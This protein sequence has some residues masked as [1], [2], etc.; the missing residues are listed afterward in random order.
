[1]RT[2]G[3]PAEYKI[4]EEGGVKVIKLVKKSGLFRPL[5]EDLIVIFTVK[6]EVR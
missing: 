6:P 5:T 3:T 1:M 2:D 4:V